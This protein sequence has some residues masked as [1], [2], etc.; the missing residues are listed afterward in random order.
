MKSD[1]AFLLFCAARCTYSSLRALSDSTKLSCNK[2]DGAC[3]FPLRG[4]PVRSSSAIV[5]RLLLLLSSPS[6]SS[7]MDFLPPLGTFVPSLVLPTFS[8]YSPLLRAILPS[9]ILP[10]EHQYGPHERHRV[11]LY[12]GAHH[13]GEKLPVIIFLHG[14]GLAGGDKQQKM[15][16]GAWQNVGTF[17]ARRGFLTVS[18]FLDPVTSCY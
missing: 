9:L 10:I 7:T 12:S 2:K 14:G 6:R 5:F 8:I 18:L 11:D 1:S 15:P 13:T 16:K 4:T 3:T 17:F